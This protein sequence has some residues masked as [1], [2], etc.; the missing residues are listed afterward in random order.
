M[1]LDQRPGQLPEQSVGGLSRLLGLVGG[2]RQPGGQHLEQRAAEPRRRLGHGLR[3]GVG[4]GRLGPVRGGQ[5]RLGTPQAGRP[6]PD[7]AP[8][9]VERG[10]DEVRRRACRPGL[11]SREQLAEIRRTQPRQQLPE[12]QFT[13]QRL[14]G[15]VP[16]A[17]GCAVRQRGPKISRPSQPVSGPP[18]QVGL[19]TGPPQTQVRPQDLAE[20]RMEP[21]P[22]MAQVL[23]ERVL[24]VQA[25]KQRLGVPPRGQ[26]VR[27]VR[28][29]PVQDAQP[30]QDVLDVGRLPGQHL[31]RQE[32]GHRAPVRLELL[33]TDRRIRGAR[34]RHGTQPQ[35]G[36]PAPGPL[37]QVVA[38]VR[39]QAQ[40]VQP[41]QRGGLRRIERQILG[42]DLDQLTRSPVAV[43]RQQRLHT[44]QEHQ[45]EARPGVAQDELQL[46]GDLRAGHPIELVDHHDQWLAAAL[47][48]GRQRRQQPPV[49]VGGVRRGPDRLRRGAAAAV[50]SV[51]Q[52]GPEN[53][54][55]PVLGLR[56]QP[57][58][59]PVQAGHPVSRQQ[60]LARARRA[61]HDRQRGV[62]GRV[63][64]AQQPGPP[65]VGRGEHRRGDPG[66]QQ[67]GAE[68]IGARPA[69][70]GRSPSVV[71]HLY[72][73]AHPRWW[74]H[75][76]VG[77]AEAGRSP[78][79]QHRSH[80]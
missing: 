3:D 42:A 61:V 49:D 75:P 1:L 55:A 78:H 44:G 26:R 27:L 59:G 64:H 6:V 58:D 53:A 47:Q 69:R 18:V 24:P 46:R 15:E 79:L 17:G 13:D 50:E 76:D 45:T 51:Q 19:Q 71:A 28:A 8:G 16:L 68:G 77:G 29:E 74:S 56:V 43:Q 60:A 66:V 70:N 40:P 11:H 33:Q 7:V 80:P 34:R 9:E 73:G 10:P 32:V 22:R 4:P 31:R 65:Q 63:Q 39:R 37:H 41:E 12:C 25:D 5:P 38:H 36:R 67:R 14:R 57:R 52:I 48:V 20:E 35:P 30:Q 72:Q 21:V 54:G 2:A 23:D 62:R